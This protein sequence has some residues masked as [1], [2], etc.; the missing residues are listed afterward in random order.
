[1]GAFILKSN[2]KLMKGRNEI[3]VCEVDRADQFLEADYRFAVSN[4]AAADQH[5]DVAPNRG[6]L[7][8]FPQDRANMTD[9]RSHTHSANYRGHRIS[10]PFDPAN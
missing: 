8:D 5:F 7:E 9:I 6:T 2:P 10:S 3:G 1:M 4:V